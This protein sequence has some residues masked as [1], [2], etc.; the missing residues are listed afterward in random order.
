VST[1]VSPTRSPPRYVRGW[2]DLAALLAGAAL[3]VLAALPVHADSVSA[4][5]VTVFRWVN[6]VPL[7]L[8]VVWPVMQLGNLFAA[9]VAA[10]VAAAFRRWRLAAELLLAGAGVW[11]LAKQVK[12]VVERGRPGALL[13]DV[14]LRGAP[15][16]GLG[17][18]S[19]H[20]AVVAGL[21]VV[22]WP[23]LNRTGRAVCLVLLLAVC[24]ARV[25]V[26]AHFPLDVVGGAGLGMLVG[27]AVRL[28]LGRPA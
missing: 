11:L 1:A 10:L 7:S 9:P 2:A 26:G 5:E 3:L 18:V 23:W 28:L 16:G 15:S 17:F 8:A 22:A 13:T 21:L 14:H 6:G 24:L 25:Q 12:R 27:G 19:G 20:A 4:A